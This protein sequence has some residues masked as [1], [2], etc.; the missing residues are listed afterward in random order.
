MLAASFLLYRGWR[1]RQHQLSPSHDAE[2]KLQ[3]TDIGSS[4]IGGGK[5]IAGA[6]A[7]IA[8]V[9]GIIPLSKVKVPTVAADGKVGFL[10]KH[11]SSLL[12]SQGQVA[13]LSLPACLLQ[14]GDETVW[15]EGADSAQRL[16]ALLPV[17][18]TPA[19]PAPGGVHSLN[20]LPDS[21]Q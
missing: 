16:A 2:G 7:G 3:G 12:Q 11:T 20:S 6:A 9:A 4:G 21:S 17:P 15:V 18:P 14:P 19:R 8:G 1:Q 5:E 13:N 10:G